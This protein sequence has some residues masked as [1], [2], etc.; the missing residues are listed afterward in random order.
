MGLTIFWLIVDC[1]WQ[2]RRPPPEMPARLISWSYCRTHIS[3][4]NVPPEAAVEE[5]GMLGHTALGYGLPNASV[6]FAVLEMNIMS[7]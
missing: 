7:G 6:S 2:R 4:Q 3:G 1:H 5:R